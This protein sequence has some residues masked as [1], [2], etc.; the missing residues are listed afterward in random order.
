MPMQIESR[1]SLRTLTYEARPCCVWTVLLL[2]CLISIGKNFVTVDLAVAMQSFKDTEGITETQISMMFAAGY[3]FSIFGKVA[4]GIGSDTL[5]GKKT[6]VIA[7]FTYVTATFLMTLVPTGDQY[8]VLYIFLWG[9]NVLSALGIM[10]VAR[11]AIATNWIPHT[12]L[13]R[14]MS[15]VSMST[16]LGDALCRVILAPFL[17]HG[18]K[19]VFRIG[20]LSAF[21]TGVPLLFVS[22]SPPDS[23]DTIQAAKQMEDEKQDGKPKKSFWQKVKPLLSSVMLYAVCVLSCVLYGTRTLFLNYAANFLAEVRCRELGEGEECLTS[24]ETLASTAYASSAFTLFGCFSPLLLGSMKD[25]LPAKHRAFPLVLFI[26]P[27]VMTLVFLMLGNTSMSYYPAVATMALAG[28]FLAGP[29]KIINV[30]AVDI[31]GKEAKGTALSLVGISNNLAAIALILIK[32]AMGKDWTIMFG[33]LVA[34][35]LVALAFAVYMWIRDLAAAKSS[36]PKEEPLLSPKGEEKDA[37]FRARSRRESFLEI[38]NT[39][40]HH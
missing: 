11:V 15:L 35:S 32:G 1:K 20:A 34:M 2:V 39:N 31:A 27:L 14:L 5:G 19:T 7:C 4:G 26:G 13:G 25:A 9:I 29:F 18:W 33:V 36:A 38:K 23:E 3:A 30:F 28:A 17:T 6:C 8:F 21:L 12:H 16:D 24:A 10:G 40:F 37:V 22:D